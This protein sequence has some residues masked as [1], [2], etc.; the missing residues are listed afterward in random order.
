LKLA[1]CG[2]KG[3]CAKST[4]A[5]NIAIALSRQ[6]KDV[7]LVDGDMQRSAMDFTAVR[8]QSGPAGYTAV[9]L[10]GTALRSQVEKLAGKYDHVIIDVGGKDSASIRAAL[11]VA[12]IALIPIPPS[13]FDIWALEQTIAL[14]EEVRP[15]NPGIIA[16]AVISIAD[17]QGKDNEEAASL[18]REY[19]VQL[20]STTVVRRKVFRNASAAG[21]SVLEYQ[22]QD[23]KAAAEIQ[24]L[25]DEIMVISSSYDSNMVG[26]I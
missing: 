25:C 20:L 6:G 19:P 23:S 14:I 9:E 18:V 8:E 4:L 1:I 12:D 16:L 5:T 10:H 26:R 22:P 15:L 11:V 13:S 24:A 17:P 3:G 21:K 7:L 2:T